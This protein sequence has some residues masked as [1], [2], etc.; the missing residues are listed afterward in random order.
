MRALKQVLTILKNDH[1]FLK[2]SI[3]KHQVSK[4]V[5]KCINRI[6]PEQFHDW[7]KSWDWW[8]F[9]TSYFNVN[10]GII[11][12][13]LFVPSANTSK[14]GSK[15]LKVNGPRIW[16]KLPSYLKYASSL[17]IIINNLFVPSANTSKY[18]SKQLKVNGPRIWN[19]LTSYLKYASSLNV[20]LKN[21]KVGYISQYS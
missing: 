13:N 3:Y 9:Y 6:T 5:F 4:F 18:G 11:I 15:Q 16:N 7:Y 1:Y 20:F 21:L 17:N 14:Y 19:K 8:T 10:D 2:L 12:N